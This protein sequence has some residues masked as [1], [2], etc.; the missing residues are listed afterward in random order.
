[1]RVSGIDVSH[2]QKLINWNAVAADNVRFCFIK[3]TEGTTGQD[4]RFA[5]NWAG[6]RAAGL[7]RGAYHFLSPKS[8]V[9][10]QVDNFLQTAGP[11]QPDDL[12]PA[13]DME[14]PAAW[15]DVPN[16]ADWA[17][18]WLNLMESKLHVV[19]FFYSN[20]DFI[21][22]VLKNDARFAR[23]PL[24]L[25]RYSLA[26][27]PIPLPWTAWSIWQYSQSGAIAGIGTA[28]D[29]DYADGSLPAMSGPWTP[30]SAN[31]D[32]IAG[33]GAPTT[34]DS[35]AASPAEAP[36]LDTS[37]WQSI[38]VE[39]NGVTVD[40]AP[41]VVN[42]VVSELV[43]ALRFVLRPNLVEDYVLRRIYVSSVKDGKHSATSLHYRRRAVDISRLNDKRLSV[44]Y[45]SDDEVKTLTNALQ[46]VFEQF[47]WRYENY[48]PHF[49]LKNGI[50]YDPGGH[51]D[52]VHFSVQ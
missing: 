41:S 13:L 18:E 4:S 25:A 39:I 35:A 44:Y 26:P 3:A 29:L 16:P 7:K 45:P 8:A 30:V 33:E 46:T 9:Q 40:F 20:P 10:T 15:Q 2:H 32:A 34:V 52:H 47:A 17:I 21:N 38:P 42:E 5:G 23:Y 1:M 36:S 27:G 24:W 11:L 50:P 43:D 6:A 48:G 51:A 49:K 14:G 37:T 19:P 12:V 28:V 31:T 22:S